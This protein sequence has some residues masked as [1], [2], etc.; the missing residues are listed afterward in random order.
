MVDISR[1][2]VAVAQQPISQTQSYQVQQ[3]QTEQ[4]RTN[5]EYAYQKAQQAQQQAE[6]A[7][8][9]IYHRQK[10][11]PDQII[12]YNTTGTLS[13]EEVRGMATPAPGSLKQWGEQQGG[14]RDPRF[15]ASLIDMTPAQRQVALAD[16]AAGNVGVMPGGGIVSIA[17]QPRQTANVLGQTPQYNAAQSSYEGQI[18]TNF[19]NIPQTLIKPTTTDVIR[20]QQSF[21]QSLGGQGATIAAQEAPYTK[22][23]ILDTA[24]GFAVAPYT[25]EFYSQYA[26]PAELEA[27]NT[28]SSLQRAAAWGNIAGA[29]Q[30][31]R[32]LEIQRLNVQATLLQEDIAK[33]NAMPE[34]TMDEY[35]M[36]VGAKHNL[37]MKLDDYNDRI[38]RTGMEAKSTDY[39]LATN[40]R[41]TPE[42][43]IN[44][45][46][47]GLIRD[48]PGTK[49][50]EV[51]YQG[52]KEKTYGF[53]DSMINKEPTATG[54]ALAQTSIGG[55]TDMI[56]GVKTIPGIPSE[57]D[58]RIKLAGL[59]PLSKA[60][61]F[62][63]TGKDV[64]K[65]VVGLP[66]GAI[67]APIRNPISFIGTTA[68]VGAITLG[69][70]AIGSTAAKL[71]LAGEGPIPSTT[72]VN[73]FRYGVP[74]KETLKVLARQ[75]YR[76][77]DIGL[78]LAVPLLYG[79][80]KL[81]QT[82]DILKTQG[83]YKAGE[84]I[85]GTA[86]GEVL[87][88]MLGG[89]LGLQTG[90]YIVG[91]ARNIGKTEI[92]AEQIIEPNILSGEKRFP[93]IGQSGAKGRAQLLGEFKSDKYAL[94]DRKVN[95]QVISEG[96]KFMRYEKPSVASEFGWG[97]PKWYDSTRVAKTDQGFF[98]IQSAE[99][100]ALA[101]V[102]G[103]VEPVPFGWHTAKI[104]FQTPGKT[105]KGTSELPGLYVGPSVSPHFLGVGSGS[106]GWKGIHFFPS[107]MPTTI[108][109]EPRGGIV[110]P[111]L[112]I[113]K[114]Y[115]SRKLATEFL[116]ANVGSEKGYVTFIKSEKEAVIPP[117]VWYDYTT[118]R[119]DVNTGKEVSNVAN[120]YFFRYEGAKIPIVEY[121]TTSPPANIV[122]VTTKGTPA[123]ITYDILGKLGGK[124][125]VWFDIKPSVAP[126]TMTYVVASKLGKEG[127]LFPI[128]K[129]TA[130]STAQ[131][132]AR[133]ESL[134]SRGGEIVSSGSFTGL[135][136]ISEYFKD[137]S[138]S[139][140]LSYISRPSSPS[141]SLTSSSGEPSRISS[142]SSITPPTYRS[143]VGPSEYISPPS[144][145]S[146][147]SRPS[148]GSYT[149]G[150][151]SYSIT[152][153]S[154]TPPPDR[155]IG[156]PR[157]E[158]DRRFPKRKKGALGFVPMMRRRKQWFA[159]SRPVSAESA[160][161]I[162]AGTTSRTL[163][164][165]FKIVPS[166]EE[167]RPT[168]AFKGAFEALKRTY[169]TTN[170]RGKPLEP[171]MFMQIEKFRLGSR[172]EVA[173]IQA[174]RR[175]LG[176]KPSRRPIARWL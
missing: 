43:A 121:V 40:Y 89:Y 100:K 60:Y 83:G 2:E 70:G 74:A 66:F 46:F 122:T 93:T 111:E 109:I 127:Q 36:K 13:A 148:R 71:G 104:P 162:G 107:F 19:G 39:P 147:P 167:A 157:K 172:S 64:L 10:G 54:I 120:K 156:P 137:R 24:K 50:S 141:Y 99:T 138:S 8:V 76:S 23:G 139:G 149:P 47:S 126:T 73:A 101:D 155:I 117:D 110:N 132:L 153:S 82:R 140:D 38:T 11:V 84:F 102:L 85:G 72:L 30:Q 112:K 159:L 9:P 61:S 59:S 4:A 7:R 67:E 45:G 5:A 154:Y 25:S 87:P 27:L 143:S 173:E 96:T 170:R 152:G 35:Q 22:T 48:L 115:T 176:G 151:P 94:P 158:P 77:T 171:F 28:G 128:T 135:G 131:L 91:E 57:I 58:T 124:Q 41:M 160:L 14:M 79:G 31:R 118:K 92:P 44:L 164:A 103:K 86:T 62:F 166:K 81:W 18:S 63:P 161:D 12:G 37:D 123:K 80:V 144:Y 113:G 49:L 95:I 55:I 1:A 52:F 169:R 29:T 105:I 129:S 106:S 134:S 68:A 142:T 56:T 65:T 26:T 17:N 98:R 34:N 165:T 32:D 133:A 53:F 78:G 42:R 136:Y 69:L 146:T 97:K 21:F 33:Y 90:K 145:P 130:I 3:Q 16:Y 168:S 174:A 125:K 108:Y 88:M 51:A 150:P 20:S 6:V 15:E 116:K 175:V 163:G 119:I 114:G 75:A